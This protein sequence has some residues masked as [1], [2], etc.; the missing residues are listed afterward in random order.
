MRSVAFAFVLALAAAPAA[1]QKPDDLLSAVV[2]VQAKALPNARSSQT[3]GPERRG[4][5]ALIRE[6]V[7]LTIGYLVVEAQSVQITGPDGKAV[8]ASVAAYDHVSGFALLRLLAPYNARPLPLGDSSALGEG[9]LAMAVSAASGEGPALVQVLSRRAFTGSWEYALDSA[10]YTYPP[11]AEWSGA[12]LISSKGELVGIGSLIV[13]NAGGEGTQSPGNLFV[14]VDVLKPVLADLIA[15][16]RRSDPP[17]PWLGMST[18]EV[19][20][21]LLVVRVASE[22]PAERAGLRAGDVIVAAAG[23]PVSS[24]QE[25]YR[26]VWA[27]GAAG[28]EVPLSVLQGQ[29]VR[30]V[31]VRSVDR[32]SYF[33]S[34]LTY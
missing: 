25:L 15:D 8:P 34:A 26:V 9:E 28:V 24:L 29:N 27:Q 18:E 1:A 30:E 20:G 11:V 21:R 32:T 17:R 33:R 5:G 22:G 10:I 16:G 4:S 19:R 7:V 31:R 23:E 3:L 13:R 6:G 12:P 14:P 2:A